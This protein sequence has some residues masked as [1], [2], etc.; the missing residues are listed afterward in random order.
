MYGREAA[1][2]A[3][4]L[5]LFSTLESISSWFAEMIWCL[6]VVISLIVKH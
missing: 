5:N 1:T 4:F 6:M 2:N 3:L